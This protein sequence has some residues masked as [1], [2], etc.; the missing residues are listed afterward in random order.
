VSSTAAHEPETERADGPGG[1]DLPERLAA[2]PV[3]MMLQLVRLARRS[4]GLAGRRNAPRQP[5]QV[6][7]PHFAVLA[8]LAADGP[9]SQ[10]EVADRIHFDASDLVTIVD[11]LEEDGYLARLRDEADRRRYLLTLTPSGLVAL[12][13]TEER[14]R[15]GRDDFLAPLSPAERATLMDLLTRLYVHHSSAAD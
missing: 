4:G 12:Q 13:E 2:S 1:A 11:V 14:A 15:A 6:R 8:V 9:T 3:F 5:G 10:R 7:L